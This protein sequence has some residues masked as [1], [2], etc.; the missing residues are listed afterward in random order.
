MYLAG[1]KFLYLK[2]ESP[3]CYH[4]RRKTQARFMYLSCLI[5]DQVQDFR[6]TQRWF[7]YFI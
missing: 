7:E 4:G 5:Q 2:N 1:S 6:L 3:M